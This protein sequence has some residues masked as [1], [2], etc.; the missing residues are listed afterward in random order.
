MNAMWVG[1]GILVGLVALVAIGQ[2]YVTR[3]TTRGVVD[4]SRARAEL[5]AKYGKS[6]DNIRGELLP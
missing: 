5:E 6:N 3:P 4:P 1:I 2:W